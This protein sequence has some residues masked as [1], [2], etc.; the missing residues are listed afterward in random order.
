MCENYKYNSKDFDYPLNEDISKVY[1]A[2]KNGEKA[3]LNCAI[4][5]V[6]YTIKLSVKNG[7]ITPAQ[8]AEMQDYFW[9]LL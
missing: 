8:G 5:D 1:E 4:S 9:R 7:I 3:L 2:E 6:H